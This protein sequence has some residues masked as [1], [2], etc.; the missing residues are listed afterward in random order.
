M[1]ND[2][3]GVIIDSFKKVKPNLTV[4]KIWT[5]SKLS[6]V[7]AVNHPESWRDEMDPYYVY[8]AGNIDG[9]TLTDNMDIVDKVIRNEYLIYDREG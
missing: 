2:L 6:I 8:S 3:V 4:M 9:L 1:G 7:L 5:K